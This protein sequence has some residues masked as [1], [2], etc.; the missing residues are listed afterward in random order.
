[1]TNLS[2][3]GDYCVLFQE[4]EKKLSVALQSIIKDAF[5][6]L[7]SQLELELHTLRKNVKTLQGRVTKLESKIKEVAPLRGDSRSSINRAT[8]SKSTAENVSVPGNESFSVSCADAAAQ[9]QFRQLQ[10]QVKS[11]QIQSEMEKERENVLLGNLHEGEDEMDDELNEKLKA[12]LTDQLKLQ[13]E[14]SQVL[15]VG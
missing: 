11:W 5:S 12:V 10:S 4:L 1:M 13:L 7:R 6:S 14:P 9:E 3:R 15:R 8:P 2:V